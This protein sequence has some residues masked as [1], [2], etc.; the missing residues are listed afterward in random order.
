MII[1]FRI[2]PPLASTGGLPPRRAPYQSLYGFSDEFVKEY[3]S[4]IPEQLV[5]MLDQAGIDKVVIP[6]EDNE[7]TFGTKIPNEKLAEFCQR[8]PKRLIGLAGVDPHKG[9]TAVRELEHA[10]K[11]LGLAGLN[12]PPFLQRLYPTDRRYYPLYAKCIELDVPVV[13]HVGINFFQEATMKHSHPMHLDEVATDFPELKIV[14]TH[15]GW[16]WVAE[17]MA[18]AWKHPNVYIDIAS[19]NPKYLGMPTMGWGPLL[20]L[21]NT[22]LQDRVLFATRFPMLSYDRVLEEFRQLPLKDDVKEKWLW[23]NA[24]NLL[25]LEV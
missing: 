8:A 5:L 14:A 11:G 1:D 25:R 3:T 24:V 2:S 16:P 13:L 23:K 9:M 7:S 4:I 12:L 18:V 19:Q 21:G 6:A 15:G 10:V 22:L 17:M 20:Q